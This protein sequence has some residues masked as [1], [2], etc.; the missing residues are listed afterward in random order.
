MQTTPL[1]LHTTG[2]YE[3]QSDHVLVLVALRDDG[4]DWTDRDVHQ[5]LTAHG[6]PVGWVE[7]TTKPPVDDNPQ[8]G[9]DMQTTDN[10]TPAIDPDEIPTVAIQL[11]GTDGNAYA[12]L[13]KVRKA[14]RRQVD[15]PQ[16]ARDIWDAYEAEATDGDYDHLL[17]TTMRWFDVT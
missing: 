12:I 4:S 6:L 11:T 13:G 5:A 15:D 3:R 17:A 14:V 10:P 7:A 9:T 16:M 1:T 2:E 8:R